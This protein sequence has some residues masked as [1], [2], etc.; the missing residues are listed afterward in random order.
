M[1]AFGNFLAIC[2]KKWLIFKPGGHL[3]PEEQIQRNICKALATMKHVVIFWCESFWFL[4]ASLH[5]VLHSHRS[6]S[7]GVRPSNQP[8]HGLSISHCRESSE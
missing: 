7:A 5:Q 3:D 4:Q 6:I 1:S 2:L 8:L